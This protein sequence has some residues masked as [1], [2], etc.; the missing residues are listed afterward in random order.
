MPRKLRIGCETHR[1]NTPKLTTCTAAISDDESISDG[2]DVPESVPAK[3]TKGKGKAPVQPESEDEQEDGSDEDGEDEYSVD[4][5]VA[6]DFERNGEVKYQVKWLGY[7]DE[8]D[9]TWEPAENLC[10]PFHCGHDHGHDLTHLP[11]SLRRKNYRNTMT[12]LAAHRNR[13]PR[14]RRAATSELRPKL[15]SPL[16]RPTQRSVAGRA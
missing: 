2:A 12:R 1:E 14:R 3:A 5:I 15:S 10:V 11:A 7:E 16:P 13:Q 8:A 9:M 4:K 6:H